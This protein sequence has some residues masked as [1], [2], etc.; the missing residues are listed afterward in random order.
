[1]K[2]SMVEKCYLHFIGHVPFLNEQYISQSQRGRVA[3]AGGKIRRRAP[4]AMRGGGTMTLVVREPIQ[5]PFNL[6]FLPAH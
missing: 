4:V 3:K 2:M 1:M 6:L 5:L